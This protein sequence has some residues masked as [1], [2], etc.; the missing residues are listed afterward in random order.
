MNTQTNN[1]ET[2]KLNKN[3]IEECRLNEGLDTTLEGWITA[4]LNVE[5]V[6][7]DE[8]GSVWAGTINLV[9]GRWLTQAECDDLMSRIDR[10]V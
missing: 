6:E 1:I 10:G 4:A 5:C 3:W 8:S 7:I 9:M 2:G